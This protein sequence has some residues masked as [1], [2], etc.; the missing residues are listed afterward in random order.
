MEFENNLYNP[1]MMVN[2]VQCTTYWHGNDLNV[3]HVDE[4]V[5]KAFFLKLADLYTGRV[6]THRCKFLGYLGMDIDC[7][8]SSGVLIVSVIK[9]PTKVLEK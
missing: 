7:G 5:V 9:H 1:N 2:E 4:T 6:E 3:S 8:S